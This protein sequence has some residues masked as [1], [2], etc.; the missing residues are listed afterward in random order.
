MT[1]NADSANAE[2]WNYL[3]G[4]NAATYMGFD[5][6]TKDGVGQFDAWYLDCYPYL[7]DYIDT[8]IKNAKSCLEIGIGLGTV[9]RYLSR[10]LN[11][12]S[13]LDVAPQPCI[14]LRRSLEGEDVN[15]HTINKSVLEGTIIDKDG[16]K[17]DCAI[18][19]GSLH[20]SGNLE[21]A[22]DNLI[23]SVKPGGKI[24]VMVYNEFSFYRF[25]NNPLRFMRRLIES[26]F[27]INHTWSE[28]EGT[29]RAVN[30]ANDQGIAAP[31]TA[32]SSKRL[33][34]SRK[35]SKW[36]VTSENLSDFILFDRHISRKSLLQFAKFFGG[37][38]LYAIGIRSQD[39][40]S[41]LD[42]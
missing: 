29:V 27:R 31:H 21:L 10:N 39:T 13:A 42:S 6:D 32:Y 8:T 25:K 41:R 4:T 20:H 40:D 26:K 1:N 38:D 2:F 17:F 19:I 22:L 9:S 33:F 11:K 34:T 24:L 3:C 23:N 30:D 5:L 7:Q 36:T 28:H 35:D 16:E 14:F 15:L 37:L 18:A 12:L